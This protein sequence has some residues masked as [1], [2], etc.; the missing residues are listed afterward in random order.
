M[1]SKILGSDGVALNRREFVRAAAATGAGLMMSMPAW[2]Q[3]PEPDEKPEDLAVAIIGPGSQ[4]R[5]L[6][7][8][9]LKIPGIRFVAVCDIWSYHQRY[10]AN[11]LKKYDM[12]VNVYEDY[13]EMLEKEKNLDA[14]IVATPDWMHAEH[15]IACLKAGKHVYC[16]KEMSNTLEKAAEMV[17][18][19]RE[20]GK[21]LQVG[22]QRRS[23][24]RY[25][26]CLKMIEKDKI[27][28]RIT[29]TYG[30]WN[31]ARLLEL[32]WP[33][34]EPLPP[35]TLQRYGYGSMDEFRNW[36]WYRKYSGGPMCD[37]GSHQIDVFNWFLRA[38][39]KAVLASGGL[40]Y[41]N[42][43]A[44]R[45]WYDN[46]LAI[47]EYDT[48][49]GTV[50]GFYQVLN[51]TSQGGF[52]EQFMG[53]EGSL[54]VSDDGKTGFIFREVQAKQR[55][56]EDEA[57]KVEKMGKDAIELKIGETLTPEGEK[58]PKAEQ[59]KAEAMKDSRLLHLENFFAAVRG[60]AELTCPAELAYETTVSVMRA[61]DAVESGQRMKLEPAMFEV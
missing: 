22:H 20:T 10:A 3:D 32:G 41:Y 42:A 36:R 40:D 14:V 59:L 56:W 2:A 21:L 29:H 55:E 23:S 31:R 9:C 28:G 1:S 54:V 46:V 45:D 58:D 39:P 18:A 48:A 12:P 4:G 11:I 7:T 50:R 53:D 61:N 35:E 17:K 51:T 13:R 34:K 57:D 43:Q 60:K 15:S 16:E 5:L 26:H 27:L 52:Y 24:P 19:A 33:K 37:L 8:M 25:W 47:Y 6:M 30:Q 44:G 38:Q 49:P